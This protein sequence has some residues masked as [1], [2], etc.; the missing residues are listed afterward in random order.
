MEGGGHIEWN[1]KRG[2]T[3]TA[4]HMAEGVLARNGE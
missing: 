1:R 3:P 2:G 4:G